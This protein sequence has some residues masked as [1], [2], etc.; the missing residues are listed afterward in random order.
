MVTSELTHQYLRQILNQFRD[1]GELPNEPDTA[2]R[3]G[4]SSYDYLRKIVHVT[5][6]DAGLPDLPVYEF[7]PGDSAFNLSFKTL[8]NLSFDNCRCG[9]SIFQL[10]I[11]ILDSLRQG[12]DL[13]NV[14]QFSFRPG[15]SLNDLLRKVLL[16]LNT[17]AVEPPVVNCCLLLESNGD[18]LF[19]ESIDECLEL[20]SCEG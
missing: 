3:C 4:D 11:R 10:W 16:V 5:R 8:V 15:D 1:L 14:P 17:C 6:L 13:P 20:E 7:R 9:D 2:C 12:C 19:L 18:D